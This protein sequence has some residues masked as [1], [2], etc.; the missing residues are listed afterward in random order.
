MATEVKLQLPR[1]V[2]AV[3][4][5]V[6]HGSYQLFGETSRAIDDFLIE[7]TL[8]EHGRMYES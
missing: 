7:G 1:S 8:P 5:G 6:G 3:R 4:N 2:L